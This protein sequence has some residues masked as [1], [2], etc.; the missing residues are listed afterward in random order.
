MLRTDG[1]IKRKRNVSNSELFFQ[2]SDNFLPHKNLKFISNQINK[3]LL[4]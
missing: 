1:Q 4:N 2:E 3:P